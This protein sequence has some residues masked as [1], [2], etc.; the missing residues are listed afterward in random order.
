MEKMRRCGH[1]NLRTPLPHMSL[2]LGRILNKMVKK[3]TISTRLATNNV[4]ASKL[5]NLR[6]Y[7]T[8]NRYYKLHS[9]IGN[10]HL[11]TYISVFWAFSKIN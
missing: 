4:F 8:Q 2:G 5:C 11:D 1:W 10:T 6:M 3:I 7:I 9:W